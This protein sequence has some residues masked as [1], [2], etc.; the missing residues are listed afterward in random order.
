M[1]CRRALFVCVLMVVFAGP[2]LA[3]SRSAYE[4]LEPG[5]ATRAEVDAKLGAGQLASDGRVTYRPPAGD[6]EARQIVVVYRMAPASIVERIEVHFLSPKPATVIHQQLGLPVTT[7]ARV[8]VGREEFFFPALQGA[9]FDSAGDGALVSALTYVTAAEISRACAE[10][11][12]RALQED[13]GAEAKAA[14]D[15][16]ILIAPGEGAGQVALARYLMGAK[17]YDEAIALLV[18][19]DTWPARPRYEAYAWLGSLYGDVKKDLTKAKAAFARALELAPA[20]Q[21]AEA[22]TLYGRF[23]Q[24][25][26]A[27]TEALAEFS[28]ALASD[29]AYQAA[30]YPLAEAAFVARDFAG[31]LRH[32]EWLYRAGGPPSGRGDETRA[33]VMW[34]YAYC[35]GQTAKVDDAISTF[36][37]YMARAGM[38]E[39]ALNEVGALSERAG[40]PLDAIEAYRI[41]QADRPTATG[42]VNLARACFA[43]GK[44]AE[45]REY[46]DAALRLDPALKTNAAFQQLLAKIK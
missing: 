40:K 18:A 26:N 36:W 19:P 7:R 2:A 34:R 31:A 6:R 1:C 10:E 42:A 25:Q 33:F 4:G 44:I 38:D 17:Q 28:K 22:H 46:A 8:P 37:Q 23:L 39:A 14:A 11:A 41:N 3:Q 24:R 30:R 35:L 29:P 20:A 9:L 12:L 16:A 43:A 15:K 21:Q 5:R 45:A 13:H 32:Y 27:A